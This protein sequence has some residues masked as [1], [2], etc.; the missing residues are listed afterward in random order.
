MKVED[1]VQFWFDVSCPFCWIT[2]RWIKEVQD[3]RNIKVDFIP[4]SLSVLNEGRDEL[5]EDYKEKMKAN[6]GPARVFAAVKTNYPEKI[7]QLYTTMGNKVHIGQRV[8]SGYGGY[9]AVIKESLEEVGLPASLA[10]VANT[11]EYDYKLRKYHRG[12][13]KAVGNDVGTP[14]I[15][16]GKTAFFGPVLTRIPTK[17]EAGELF[18]AAVRLAQYPHFFELKRSRTEKPEFD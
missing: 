4:M 11:E 7:D 14:V 9:D 15:S 18:D 10:E 17:E 16:L 3:V 2:S 6:W 8:A 12:A 1:T 5:P 13:M